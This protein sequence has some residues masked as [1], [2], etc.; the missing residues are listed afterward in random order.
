MKSRRPII[1]FANLWQKWVYLAKSSLQFTVQSDTSNNLTPGMVTIIC[2]VTKY[3]LGQISWTGRTAEN[4]AH[5]FLNFLK[6]EAHR[7]YLIKTPSDNFT[8]EFPEKNKDK[9]TSPSHRAICESACVL[10][11]HCWPYTRRWS[12]WSELFPPLWSRAHLL[13]YSTYSETWFP[14]SCHLPL[15][16]P[17]ASFPQLTN[18]SL[19]LKKV[20]PST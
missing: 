12:L 5:A 1:F 6:Y 2:L 19:I 20:L 18:I 3:I 7:Y 9:G 16:F 14:S 8:S 13:G 4:G 10:P 17:M 15:P 11:T